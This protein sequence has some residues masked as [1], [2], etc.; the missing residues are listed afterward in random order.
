M[1]P[2]LSGS[3]SFLRPGGN[4]GYYFYYKR[5]V[6]TMHCLFV[7]N[8]LAGP[9][10][11]CEMIDNAKILGIDVY[12]C[13]LVLGM[14]FPS[15]SAS[16]KAAYINKNVKLPDQKMTKK[17]ETKDGQKE[18]NEAEVN[19]ATVQDNKSNKREENEQ[20]TLSIRS[21]QRCIQNMGFFEKA[22]IT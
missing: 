20:V 8:L 4:S 17:T 13:A 16:A 9:G 3:P 19:D 2:L 21:M 11:F 15:M 14:Y 10:A 1:R 5:F 7:K 18:G 6:P 22:N 12:V